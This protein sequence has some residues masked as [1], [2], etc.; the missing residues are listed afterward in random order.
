MKR[1]GTSSATG[2]GGQDNR[3]RYEGG[4]QAHRR[5][6]KEEMPKP[7]CGEAWLEQEGGSG[8]R[9]TGYSTLEES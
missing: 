4:S 9:A 2:G 6:G 1:S 8:G 7:S 5:A 3:N